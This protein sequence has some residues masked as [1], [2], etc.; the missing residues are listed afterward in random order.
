MDMNLSKLQEVVED[1]GAWHAAVH[2]VANSW[3]QLSDW[4][5]LVLTPNS[6]THPPSGQREGLYF[7]SFW[8][9]S[10]SHNLLLI[11]GKVIDITSGQKLLVSQPPIAMILRDYDEQI[12]LPTPR[13][14][15]SEWEN[16]YQAVIWVLFVMHNLTYRVKRLSTAGKRKSIGK[17]LITS[18]FIISLNTKYA[19]RVVQVWAILR[20][21]DILKDPRIYPP[22]TL[23]TWTSPFSRA[24]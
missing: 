7:P 5:T 2:G 20:F 1:R 17:W 15:W 16:L 11:W 4:T 21:S 12:S 3:T 6:F 8:R 19:N 10:Y 13:D 22:A 24:T 14:R 9:K 18:T 23:S